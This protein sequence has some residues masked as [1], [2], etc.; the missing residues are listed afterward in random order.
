MI[1]WLKSYKF[2]FLFSLGFSAK[3]DDD[4]PYTTLSYANGPA[5]NKTY[6]VIDGS[7]VGRTDLRKVDIRAWEWQ[8]PAAVPRE[9]ETHAGDDVAIY[10]I[11]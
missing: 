9:T 7:T 6:K 8:R 3:G 5:F 11:G 10:A 2:T 4:L 1:V